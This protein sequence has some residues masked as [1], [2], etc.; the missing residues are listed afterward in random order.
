MTRERSR[1]SRLGEVLRA[2][3]DRLPIARRL[4]DYALWPHWDAVAGPTVAQHARPERMQRGVLVV[5]VDGVEWMQELQFLKH[6][7]RER[8]NVR[9]GRPAVRDIFLVLASDD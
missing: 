7:L 9:L 8:L 1:P 6:E 4:D 5:R 3:L 2:A